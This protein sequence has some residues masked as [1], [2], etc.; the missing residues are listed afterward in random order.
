M[1]RR[2]ILASKS[3]RR[4]DILTDHGFSPIILPVDADETLPEGI[5]MEEAVRMLAHIKA[6]ACYDAV[7]NNPEYNDCLIIGADTIVYKDRIMGKSADRADG[8]EML[9]TISGTY[10]FVSTG[11]SIIDAAT[12][13]ETILNDVT[14]V[15]CQELSEEQ[16]N[17]Y[18]DTDEPYDKAGAYAIQGIFGKYI[19]HFE[20]DYENVVGLPFNAIEEYLK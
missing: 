9:S 5:E 12:G 3:P 6:K 4:L 13:E 14:K 16:I 18:L 1:K 10:H 7:S 8:F 15:Y 17:D 20:G 2:I 11:V 19:D